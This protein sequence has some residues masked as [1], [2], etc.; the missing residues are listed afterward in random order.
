MTA[1]STAL[2]QVYQFQKV[3]LERLKA[4]HSSILKVHYFTDGCGGQYKNQYNF[5]NLCHHKMDFGLLAELNFFATSQG[6]S[7]CDG[8]GGTVKR[9]TMRASLQR[10]V[11]EQILTPKDMF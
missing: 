9:G 11:R 6:K 7:A 5:V 3:L 10:P 8:I 1:R 4:K 2:A